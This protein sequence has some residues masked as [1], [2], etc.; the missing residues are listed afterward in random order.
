MAVVAV[1]H[2]ILEIV[3]YLLAKAT[4]YHELGADYID[5]RDKERIVH[6]HLHLLEQLG[7]RVTIEPAPI[8]A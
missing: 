8:A 2:A 1:A 7:Y 6:R 5:R 4:T 3:W